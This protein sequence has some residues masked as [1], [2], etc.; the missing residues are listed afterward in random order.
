MKMYIACE[1]VFAANSF[2]DK[3]KWVEIQKRD[4]KIFAGKHLDIC[5]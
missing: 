1:S 5:L 2:Q 4:E 3:I